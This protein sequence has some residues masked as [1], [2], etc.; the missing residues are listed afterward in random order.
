MGFAK[1]NPLNVLVSLLYPQ[2]CVGC[3]EEMETPGEI[4][5]DCE[6]RLNRIAPPL[7]AKCSEPF[8][9]AIAGS[10]ECANCA[11]RE[12]HFE[13]AVSAFRARGM[14]RDIIL[15]FKY[16]RQSRLQ[17]LV[18]SWLFQ[19]LDDERLNGRIFDLIVP[20][21][22]HPAKQRERGFNQAVLLAQLLARK[23]LIPMN[24]AL[25]RIR[26][27]TTQT[28]LDRSERMKNLHGAF[29][30]RRN[31]DVRNSRVLLVDDVLTTGST[32]SECAR[33][34]KKAGAAQ[35]FA[36]TAARA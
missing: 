21:P 28:A 4:C 27:T 29:R 30:L 26:Y 24:P 23:I 20:V 2:T 32:L 18:G 7:C 3:G 15:D 17:H 22:L 8:S 34:L 16:G 11:D 19:A 5:G 12:L 9:G 1:L 36:V 35:V 31:R 33:V 10:F 25:E 6:S 14:V 13:A